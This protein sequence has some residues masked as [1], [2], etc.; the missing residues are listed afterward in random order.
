V[1]ALEVVAIAEAGG[2]VLIGTGLTAAFI[3]TRQAIAFARQAVAENWVKGGFTIVNPD[4]RFPK[5]PAVAPAEPA[6][7]P[8]T[9][10]L[11]PAKPSLRAS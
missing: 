4:G 6:P 1:T 7:R 3:L 9:E 5:L 2:F 8:V 11:T 10:T